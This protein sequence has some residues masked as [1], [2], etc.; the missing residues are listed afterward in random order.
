Y[1]GLIGGVAKKG[2]SIVVIACG[3]SMVT[4]EM[5]QH[6]KEVSSPTAQSAR[7]L[8]SELICSTSPLL[9]HRSNGS[10]SG[11]RQS[12]MVISPSISMTDHLGTEKMAGR[13]LAHT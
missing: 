5:L 2:D 1:H 9:N 7:K 10:K 11:S 12:R 8:K 3:G 4:L 13:F 6:W